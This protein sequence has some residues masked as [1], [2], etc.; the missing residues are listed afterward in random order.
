MA[1]GAHDAPQT[2][3]SAGDE[4]TPSPHPTLTRRLRY[5]YS[6]AFGARQTSVPYFYLRLLATAVDNA[7]CKSLPCDEVSKTSCDV[8]KPSLLIHGEVSD[9][10]FGVV[11]NVESTHPTKNTNKTEN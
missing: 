6:R 1:A 5:L 3:W 9:V 11:V 8:C 10:V 7:L 4:D 2:H